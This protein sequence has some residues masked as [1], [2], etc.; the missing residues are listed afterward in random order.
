MES[1]PYN[2]DYL[3]R[4]KTR[5]IFFVVCALAFV[6][7]LFIWLVAASHSRLEKLYI[8]KVVEIE[9]SIHQIGLVRD[10]KENKAI[11]LSPVNRLGGNPVYYPLTGTYSI[12]I[13]ADTMIEYNQLHV[14]ANEQT[15]QTPNSVNIN[16]DSPPPVADGTAADRGSG[17]VANIPDPH[18]AIEET[19]P[20]ATPSPKPED[21]EHDTWFLAFTQRRR[22]ALKK[23]EDDLAE[24]AQKAD[25]IYVKWDKY[26]A[27]CQ[28]TTT[29][30]N[31]GATGFDA[32]SQGYATIWFN[33]NSNI[34][35]SDLPECRLLLADVQ[36]LFATIKAGVRDVVDSARKAGFPYPGEIRD[37]RKKY[38]LEWEGWD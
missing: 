20:D 16:D 8:G 36:A 23:S 6:L 22:D 38:H 21:K 15:G 30:L 29:V 31:S 26:R 32:R 18:P 25:E 19:T 5:T 2:L 24:L 17:R 27:G 1:G 9:G 33:T 13:I 35:N 10:F 3:Q 37:L 14:H 12:K 11:L 7:G 34:K 28:G 4:R